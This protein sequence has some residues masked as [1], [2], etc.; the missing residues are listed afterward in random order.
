MTDDFSHLNA[1]RFRFS[2]ENAHLA[3]R[4]GDSLRMVWIA[5][6]EKEIASEI[7]FLAARGIFEPLFPKMT[8]DE[9][10]AELAGI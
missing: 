7:A 1:L 2:R 3:A 10:L 9:L 8:D 5:Q 6:L 4:P